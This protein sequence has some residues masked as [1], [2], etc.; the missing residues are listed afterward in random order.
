MISG[1]VT[2]CFDY[3]EKRRLYYFDVQFYCMAWGGWCGTAAASCC[4]W[5]DT[6]RRAESRKWR[7]YDLGRQ[8]WAAA[9]RRGRRWRG[10]GRRIYVHTYIYGVTVPVFN[11]GEKV[12]GGCGE[13]TVKVKVAKIRV[14]PAEKLRAR[15]NYGRRRYGV[16][17]V[18]VCIRGTEV[19]P[20]RAVFINGWRRWRR[21]G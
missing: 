2:H 7:N 11:G 5:V 17:G 21:G 3:F 19:P 10:F 6:T 1:A 20:R 8:G 16:A 4:K 13:H 14:W 18:Y 12:S 15:W 9:R